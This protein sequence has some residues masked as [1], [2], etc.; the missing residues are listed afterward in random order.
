MARKRFD[1]D[2][3]VDDDDRPRRSRRRDDDDYDDERP[4]R[5]R[6]PASKTPTWVWVAVPLGI[7]V[8]CGGGLTLMMT[9]VQKVK[10][11]GRSSILR[12][13]MK[14]IGIGLHAQHDVNG[15]LPVPFALDE[16]KQP[17]PGLSW[18]V[19]TL[20]F[21]EQNV[22]YVQFDRSKPWDD[23][24]N[25]FSANRVVPAYST[26]D[27]PVSPTHT[28][29]FGFNGPGAFMEANRKLPMKFTTVTDGL[30][31]TAM[32]AEVTTGAP[33]ASPTD[34]PYTRNGPLPSFGAADNNYFLMLMAD[35]SVRN[36]KKTI[37]PAVM[38][39][40]IQID[41]GQVIDLDGL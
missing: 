32:V 5:R 3:D 34:V 26:P 8:V 19:G 20:P 37:P 23:A 14:Q 35:G 40:L 31:N 25:Q 15:F 38:H 30:S 41:D 39:A 27:E 11:A 12:N 16:T 21:V 33:W 13:N 22:L 6:K 1:D 2:D 17:N 10:S 7:L 28:R 36:I 29:M 9:S 24:R 18:R 4:R